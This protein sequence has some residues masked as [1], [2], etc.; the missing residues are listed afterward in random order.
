MPDP[1]H[2]R[3]PRRLYC[4]LSPRSLPYAR[5]AFRSL[6]DHCLEPVDLTLITDEDADR[7]AIVAT[8]EEIGSAAAHRWRVLGKREADER[9]E[10]FY[11]DYPLIAVFRDGHPCWRKITDPPLFAAPGEEMII[12]DPD[13]YFPNRFTFEPTPESGLALMW[14]RPSCLLPHEV[15]MAA[16]RGS[17][18]LAHHVDIGVAQ[19]RNRLDLPWLE[20]LI[21]TL[22][23]TRLPRKMHIEAIVW[24][25]LAMHMGGGYLDP[26][27]W[28]CWRNAQ[29]KRIAT[30][31]GVP[32]QAILAAEDFA[33]MKC[34]HGGGIAKWWIPDRVAA[35]RF[36]PPQTLDE[37]TALRPFVPLVQGAYEAT[38]RRKDLARRLGYYRLFP[39]HA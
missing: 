8:I 27:R 12:L 10:T 24:A 13:L 4:V 36:A 30:K 37:A 16:Y 38:Q 33:A 21:H 17:I 14:Q 1:T 9:A 7:D 34:F 32:G 15:V 19:L 11:A 20:R 22:G 31:V 23:G 6:F 25:A 26:R 3:T 18:R 29:W 28:S 35:G 2:A 39:A 5:L